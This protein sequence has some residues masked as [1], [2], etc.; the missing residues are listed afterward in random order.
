MK[1][2][3]IGFSKCGTSSI[4]ARFLALGLSS[5]HHTSPETNTPVAVTIKNNIDSGN[6]P[7]IGLD[8]Y[9]AFTDLVYLTHEVHIE[10]F[11]FFETFL[12]EIPDA[13]FILNVRDKEKWVESCARHPQLFERLMSVYGYDSRHTVAQELLVNW[14]KHIE[15]VIA[16]IPSKH[17]LIYDIEQG[18]ARDI[19]YFAGKRSSLPGELEH[20]NYTPS[21]IHEFLRR[22]LPKSIRDFLPAK[23]KAKVS[24]ALRKR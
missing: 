11:K 23:I 2:F 7:L 20:A 18:D 21:T 19:D 12:K 13:K 14:D 4:H 5:V 6:Y 24:Y 8:R 16:K 15:K 1:I 9:D 17:L 10:A 3:V 22:I